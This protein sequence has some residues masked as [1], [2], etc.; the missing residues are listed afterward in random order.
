MR[1]LY[2][3]LLLKTTTSYNK[4]PIKTCNPYAPKDTGLYININLLY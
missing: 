2:T 4:L 1:L 3:K